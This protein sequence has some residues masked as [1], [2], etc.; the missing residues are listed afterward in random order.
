MAELDPRLYTVAWIA[1]LE[2]E[3][4]AALHLLDNR[5]QGRFP[6]AP[7]DDYIFQAGDACGHNIIIATLPAGEVYGTRSAA[8]LATQVKR[9]FPNLWFG[10]LVG[11][12]AGLPVG[13][14]AGLIDYE[15]GKETRT[16]GFQ[17]LRAGHALAKTETVVRSAIGS[18]KLRAPNDSNDILQYYKR[19]EHKKHSLGTFADPGQDRDTLYQ[20]EESGITSPVVREQR[21][22]SK[23]N[24]VWYG[25]IGS[26]DK[27]MKNAQKRNELRDKY[28]IIGLE[29]EAA[30][31]MDQIP[32]GVIRGVCDYGDE[33]KNDEWQPYAASMAACY[34]KAVLAEIR[35]NN[36]I[37]C[38]PLDRAVK[39]K[40]D[41]QYFESTSDHECIKR[42]CPYMEKE[43][44]VIEMMD[45]TVRQSLLEQLYFDKIDERLMNLTAAQGKTCCWFLAKPEYISWN[46]S[47]LQPDHGGFLWI[48]G[49]PGTGKSTLMKF[50]LKRPSSMERAIHHKSYCHSSSSREL[51]QKAPEAQCSLEWMTANGA[52][53]IQRNGWHET[54]LK[55]TL[56]HAVQ[57]LGNRSLKIFVDALDEC[58]KDQVAD[59]VCFFEELCESAQESRV[60]LQVCFSSRHYPTVVIQKGIEVT[61]E[62]EIGHTE[63]IE[64]YIRSKFRLGK[65]SQAISLRSEILN[66]S[67]NIFLWVVLV[68][69]ILNREYP[70]S[71]ISIKK[72]RN[73]LREIPP[74]LNDLFEMILTRDDENLD[75]LHSGL[76]WIL[77]ANRPLKPQ[78]FY[79]AVQFSYAEEYTGYWERD[80]VAFEE[81]KTFVR[82]SSK[83]LAEV[84][85]N[86]ALEV[87][88]IH[89]SVRDFLLRKYETQWSETSDNFIGSSH[90]LLRDCCLAQ[91][92][93]LSP[94]DLGIVDPLP[95]ASETSELRETIHSNYPFL[96]YSV[97][98]TLH[99][100]NSVQ[101]NGIDQGPFL[102]EFPLGKWIFLNNAIEQFHIRRYTESASL[103]YILA[104]KNLAELA[105]I[106]PQR[107]HFFDVEMEVER[108][109]TPIFA[110]MATNSREVVY[111]FLKIL[112]ATL[113]SASPL[114]S[115]CEVYHQ[116]KT[117][118]RTFGR[119]FAFSRKKRILEY[120][121]EEGNEALIF[122]FLTLR[123][124]AASSNDTSN[125]LPLPRTTTNWYNTAFDIDLNYK[126]KDGR[127]P[128]LLAAGN[129]HGAVV[130]LLLTEGININCKD[131]NGQT[132][133]SWAAGN[134]HKDV[135]DLLLK[136]G[137]DLNRK[138]NNGRTPL[139][140]AAGNGHKDVAD[141]LLK[142]G[143]GLN[144]K[145]NY[146][147][148]PLS[149]AMNNGHIA[150]VE[151]LLAQD[152][153]DLNC[154]DNDGQTPLLW[155]LENRHYATVEL[156]LKKDGVDLNRKDNNGRTPLSWAAWRGYGA[157]I[158]LLLT[159]DSIDLGAKD[160]NGR[161]PL[162]QAVKYKNIKAVELLLKH[163]ADPNGK[164]NNGWTPLLEAIKNNSDTAIKLLLK[165]GADLNGKDFNC[166]MLLSEAAA[167]GHDGIVALLLEHGADPNGKNFYGRTPL[168]EA[169]AY[170]HDVVIALLLQ[171]GANP[172]FKDSFCWLPL[173]DAA[174][175]GHDAIV[176]LLLDH[177]ADIDGKDDYGWTPLSKAA[178]NAHDAIVTL[179]LEQ[180]ADIECKNNR[181]QTPLL[182]AT[183]QSNNNVIQLLLAQGADVD[184]KDKEGRTPLSWAAQRG[185][186]AAIQS[187]LAQGANP[188][189]KDNEGWTPLALAAKEGDDAIVRL[190][191]KQAVD[192]D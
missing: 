121:Q 116:N 1:P 190:L 98:N 94:Q 129:G 131:N 63:D 179:L 101:Q 123:K 66:K 167:K 37:Q 181:G 164:D 135:A 82:S 49:H 64:Y 68:L 16:D 118:S 160:R 28:N 46:D 130:K 89:E 93:S 150:A 71:S 104:E 6:L 152:G 60:R 2:I 99:H 156:L 147:W 148:T 81:M 174:A 39:R 186:H 36:A 113:P 154:T 137:A 57:K 78:E 100:A 74:E 41:E 33:H 139:S 48:K 165:H 40:A 50:L 182:I 67:S 21:P 47:S 19:I 45:E 24:R 18:I 168:L 96:E 105:W 44:P 112:A 88:F 192:V 128:L 184:C 20:V 56:T 163:G 145:D 149:W 52:K 3:A 91:L 143:A 43:Q 11:I 51:F 26:G 185:H 87:Q 12:A 162:L 70:N 124:L 178:A 53:V 111:A 14:N 108:Y 25:S 142:Y 62:N 84:T 7:G 155:A 13:D 132:P 176:K 61:L 138:D 95:P 69:D 134:G 65:S 85:Q 126:N 169:A 125:S 22:D 177:G 172:N 73:R 183:Q 103:L 144:G 110:G 27:L 187:L 153:V 133:L 97:I 31:T 15:L 8:A 86:K 32:V 23:R 157:A 42:Q 122:A 170:G 29:M 109:G 102:A 146:G 159:Q 158:K 188:N 54:A 92:N 10:L 127:T 173:P 76:K 161:T 136:Y 77:F 4:Q 5:H 55:Q 114:H 80:D 115:L 75:R 171:H 166:R 189:C 106:H 107:L 59:M 175:R 117:S 17:L 140:W 151:L 141:L 34:A 191:H 83:G 120:L 90:K 72:I 35:P 9:F 38:R 119:N 58:N 30:G 180:G 79:F